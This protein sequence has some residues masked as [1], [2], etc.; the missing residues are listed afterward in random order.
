MVS[1]L[2]RKLMFEVRYFALRP[3]GSCDESGDGLGDGSRPSRAALANR[4]AA[5]GD[6]AITDHRDERDAELVGDRDAASQ[7]L[8][9]I[10]THAEARSGHDH[11]DRR[12]VLAVRLANRCNQ[13]L[14]RGDPRWQLPAVML[15]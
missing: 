5:V 13:D 12:R 10:E 1:Q 7:R 3:A 2:A 15:E 14:L 11:D 8:L 4:D 9:G 6:L